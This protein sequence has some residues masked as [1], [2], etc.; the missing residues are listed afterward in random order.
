MV[1]QHT[2]LKCGLISFWFSN[3]FILTYT[4]LH[5]FI[6]IYIFL[7]E[8]YLFSDGLIVLQD[9]KTLLFKVLWHI[10]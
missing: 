6:N 8:I 4:I 10:Y 1:L 5:N 2:S 7:I 9:I 3:K